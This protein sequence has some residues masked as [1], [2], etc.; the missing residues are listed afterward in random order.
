VLYYRLPVEAVQDAA[1]RA[2][3]YRLVE[4]FTFPVRMAYPQPHNGEVPVRVSEWHPDLSTGGSA[5]K[6]II[7]SHQLACVAPKKGEA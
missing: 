4:N 7:S 1:L 2:L 3:Y 6:L 5:R